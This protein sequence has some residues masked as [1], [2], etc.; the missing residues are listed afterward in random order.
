MLVSE[1][2]AERCAHDSSSD[3]GRGAE[4]RFS[5]LPPGGVDG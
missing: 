2:F 1:L 5:R 3:A 4:V